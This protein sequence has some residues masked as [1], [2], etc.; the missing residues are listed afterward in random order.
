MC[1]Y[2]YTHTHTKYV[3]IY[4]A[5]KV[6]KCQLPSCV[7]LLALCSLWDCSPPGLFCPWNSPG[8]NTGVGCRSL[9]QGVFPMQG[10]NPGLLHCRQT[11][12]YL[13]HKYRSSQVVLVVKNP[14]A[15]AGGIRDQGLDPWV[16]KII[17]WRREWHPTPV[18]LP[19]ESHGQ[20]SLVG[21]SPQCHKE[22]DVTEATQHTRS[23]N[24]LVGRL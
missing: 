2:I 9:L 14:P 10:S 6:W 22:S 7:R 23:Y 24:D 12:Y 19:G 21:Y 17:P 11:L 3:C 15:N 13:S 18:F 16:R 8:K 5:K 20:R 4:I 1:V